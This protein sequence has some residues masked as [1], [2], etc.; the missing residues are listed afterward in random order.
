MS[1]AHYI[2]IPLI[3][4]AGML[5][6]FWLGGRAA[7]DAYNMERR[8]EEQREAAHAERA[9]RKAKKADPAAEDE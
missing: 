2:Y 8:R 5:L 6:G 9:A 7:R 1:S 3:L 4:L